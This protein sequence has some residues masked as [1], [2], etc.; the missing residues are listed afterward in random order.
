[1]L[2]LFCLPALKVW[3][4]Q[5]SI[6]SVPH[7]CNNE[8]SYSQSGFFAQYHQKGCCPNA[9]W[10]MLKIIYTRRTISIL[11]LKQCDLH[12]SPT[13]HC[14]NGMAVIFYFFKQVFSK[15]ILNSVVPVLQPMIF[16]LV[17]PLFFPCLYN[18]LIIKWSAEAIHF[19]KLVGWAQLGRFVILVPAGLGRLTFL[20]IKNLEL[21]ILLVHTR[22][23]L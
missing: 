7:R 13:K 20:Q 16:I 5:L 6:I 22:K 3:K 2:I 4:D 1:M 17:N 9:V 19:G 8:F 18:G 23:H 10:T 15:I 14:S 12:T 11:S 21:C